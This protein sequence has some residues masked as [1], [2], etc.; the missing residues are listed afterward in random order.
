MPWARAAWT[1]LA[2]HR[3]GPARGVK[4]RARQRKPNGFVGL[5]PWGGLLRFQDDR[6]GVVRF[7]QRISGESTANRARE[8]LASRVDRAFGA[9]RATASSTPRAP[10][11]PILSSS[12]IARRSRIESPAGTGPTALARSRS[13]RCRSASGGLPFSA[14]RSF[15]P[16]SSPSFASSFSASCRRANFASPKVVTRVATRSVSARGAGRRCS[17]R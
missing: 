5:K 15:G 11:S 3:P 8:T 14:S 4:A 13:I 17:L 2:N 7:S 6:E 12:S 1:L 16:A 9:P 10:L